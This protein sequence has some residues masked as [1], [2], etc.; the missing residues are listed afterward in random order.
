MKL[1]LPLVDLPAVPGD[2]GDNPGLLSLVIPEPGLVV[3]PV[4][5]P[6]LPSKCAALRARSRSP[7]VVSPSASLISA[8]R[9]AVAADTGVREEVLLPVGER[10]YELIGDVLDEDDGRSKNPG[11]DPATGT[12]DFLVPDPV[13]VPEPGMGVVPVPVPGP[14]GVVP[15]AGVRDR[16]A[17]RLD[18]GVVGS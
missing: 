8:E 16:R 6:G 13:P 7:W 14:T 5:E 1:D 18:K 12:V 2:V 11:D 10:K 9:P 4:P 17:I 3:I 15:D